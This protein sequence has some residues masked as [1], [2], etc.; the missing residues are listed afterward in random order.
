[1][2][3]SACFFQMA[4]LFAS[5]LELIWWTIWN[6]AGFPLI[7]PNDHTNHLNLELI[8]AWNFQDLA[9]I[10]ACARK[11]VLDEW[12]NGCTVGIENVRENELTKPCCVAIKTSRTQ[13]GHW[14][15]LLKWFTLHYTK[16]KSPYILHM[17]F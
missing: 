7:L 14:Y 9:M 6:E 5:Y 12:K 17:K 8:V 2:I 11:I 15:Q 13:Q 16:I 3:I 1:M 10:K 4:S